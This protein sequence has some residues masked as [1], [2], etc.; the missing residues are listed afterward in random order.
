MIQY[1]ESHEE[2]TTKDNK[3]TI[4]FTGASASLRGKAY[5]GAFA[6]AKS[7]LRT[8]SQSLAREIQPK[9]IHVSHVIVDAV[10]DNPISMEAM[11]GL[12]HLKKHQLIQPSDIANTYYFLYQ[13]NPN[14][15]TFELDTRP[16]VENW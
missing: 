9:G 13:Q 15:Y 1:K 2:E 3:Y 14:C 7:A 10:V 16:H 11:G 8:F 6:A 12:S 5:F 4:I